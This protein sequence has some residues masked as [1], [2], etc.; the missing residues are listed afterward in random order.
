MSAGAP[1]TGYYSVNGEKFK[2]FD[3]STLM[4]GSSYYYDYEKELES[5]STVL[6]HVNSIASNVASS[7]T[8]Y[9]YV[10]D[11]LVENQTFTPVSSTTTT[12]TVWSISGE[13]KHSFDESTKAD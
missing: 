11:D 5:P 9:V 10:N 12:E 3:V 1:C 6:I 8:V 2:A 4:E 13:V 7:I